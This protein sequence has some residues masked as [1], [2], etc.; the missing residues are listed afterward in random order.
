MT[1]F[2]APSA[3][4]ATLSHMFPLQGYAPAQ[5]TIGIRV[6][7][8]LGSKVLFV[9]NAAGGLNKGTYLSCGTVA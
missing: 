5:V 4:I 1:P 9:T 3:T 8:G 6:F 7:A 2:L